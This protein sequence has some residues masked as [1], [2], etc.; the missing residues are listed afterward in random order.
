MAAV[1]STARFRRRGH[2]P[3]WSQRPGPPGASA[4]TS[5]AGSGPAR[6]CWRRW[7]SA[8]APSSSAGPCSGHWPG[9]ARGA[10]ADLWG[11]APPSG[12]NR[13]G[14][15]G[16]RRPRRLRRQAG[17]LGTG[18]RRRG[19]RRRIAERA[20]RRAGPPDGAVR[21]GI[22]ER[23]SGRYLGH[24]RITRSARRERTH[25]VTEAR[26]SRSDD[27]AYRQRRYLIMMGIRVGCFVVAVVLFSSGAG[28][29]T[30][31]PAVGAII[32]P[33]FAVVF[34]NGGRGPTRQRGFQGYV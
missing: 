2:C 19:W 1:S 29:F 14:G 26:R 6:T 25:L 13:G 12:A 23:G 22:G 20:H 24:V 4:S 7:P 8:P 33:Y 10:A 21:R 30:A 3:P 32:I 9:A 11:G 18:L 15:A 31:I 27:I 5:M 34:A 28:W 17:A 16:P